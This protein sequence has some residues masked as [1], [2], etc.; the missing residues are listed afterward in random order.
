LL[1]KYS[2]NVQNFFNLR[3]GV[4]IMMVTESALAGD[5]FGKLPARGD[6]VRLGL[7][8]SFVRPWDNWCG[9]A[10]GGSQQTLGEDWLAAWLQAPVW[11]FLLPAGMCGPSSILGLW[12]PSVD[13]AGR[14]FPLTFARLLPAKDGPQQRDAEA[15]LDSAEAAGRAALEEDLSPEAVVERLR[16]PLTHDAAAQPS[17]DLSTEPNTAVW[18][19]AGGPRVAAARLT[20]RMLPPPSLF[21][22][23]LDDGSRP[24]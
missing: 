8:S 10:L 15:W 9:T 6:F 5:F 22:R 17:L 23:M 24:G 14:Y 16:G 12:L 13:G 4:E 21:S 2:K 3:F 11:R 18:W 20:L 7:P 19:T 1:P